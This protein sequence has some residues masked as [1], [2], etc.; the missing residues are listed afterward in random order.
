FGV[1]AAMDFKEKRAKCLML[2][3][4][5]LVLPSQDDAVG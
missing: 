5:D 1:D 4:K 2:L 3:V